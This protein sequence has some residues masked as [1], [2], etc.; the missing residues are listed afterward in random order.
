MEAINQER[1][2]LSINE[3]FLT[4]GKLS[5]LQQKPGSAGDVESTTLK[6]HAVL[7]YICFADDLSV[8]L[9]LARFI[10]KGKSSLQ[11]CHTNMD[12]YNGEK[13]PPKSMELS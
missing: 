4:F 6:S 7:L 13:T 11:K 8:L 5:T 3:G 12:T 10:I 2:K 1:P 9:Y